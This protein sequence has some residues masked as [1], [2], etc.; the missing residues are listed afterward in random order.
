MTNEQS[1]LIP[2][3][4]VLGIPEDDSTEPDDADIAHEA[5][6]EEVDALAEEEDN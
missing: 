3:W 4:D 1:L 6:V 5:S 2:E